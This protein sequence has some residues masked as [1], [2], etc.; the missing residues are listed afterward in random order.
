MK[1]Y[2]MKLMRFGVIFLVA[3]GLAVPAGFRGATA[4]K[5]ASYFPGGVC[6]AGT[7]DLWAKAGSITMPDGAAVPVWGFAPDAGSPAGLPGPT[8]VGEVGGTLDVVLHNNLAG[9]TVSLDF[10][11][12]PLVPD[13]TGV[14]TGGSTTYTLSLTKPG[15]FL[16]QAGLTGNGPRQVAMGLY[17]AI[18][19]RPAGQPLQAYDDV[20]TTFTDEALLVFSEIDP[21]FNANPNT[22]LMEDFNPRYWLINGKSF[23]QTEQYTV[24]AGRTVLFRYLNAGFDHH[25]IGLLGLRE[26]LVAKDSVPLSLPYM[27][28]TEIIGAGQTVDVL[29]QVPADAM[30]GKK[31][32]LYETS[33]IQHNANQRLAA[34]GPVAVGGMM[35]TITV[36]VGAAAPVTGALVINAQVNP[37]PTTGA[38]GVTL[39]ATFSTVVYGTEYFIDTI[40]DPGTGLGLGP[41]KLFVPVI[42]GGGSAPATPPAPSFSTSMFIPESIL[43]TLAGGY[44]NIYIRGKDANGVWGPVGSVVLNLDKVGPSAVG[45]GLTST[46]TNGQLDVEVRA[47]ADDLHYGGAVITGATYKIDNGATQLMLLDKPDVP[48]TA[49]TATIPAAV[50]M[51][52]SEGTHTVFVQATDSMGNMGPASSI[53]LVVDKSGPVTAP[54]TTDPP[55]FQVLQ[56]P[57]VTRVQVRATVTD[58]SIQP[59]TL[60]TAEGFIDGVGSSGT[61][62]A[63]FALDGVFD[64]VEEAV[65]FDIPTLNFPWWGVYTVTIHGKDAAGNWGPYSILNVLPEGP[66]NQVRLPEINR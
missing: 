17:G 4:V 61:G 22:Y 13:L 26:K 62:F 20:S 6:Q 11:G 35:T 19:V 25:S 40:G 56:T 1:K 43:A 28:T 52:L 33:L 41:I 39:T 55:D 10:L 5:A 7:C 50:V 42:T 63:V 65:Y 18:V 16:Y 27:V 3:L 44:H 2:T 59:S 12:F 54:I 15:T 21:L 32:L 46:P 36:A 47:T 8:L 29:V 34:A 58:L 51:G 57:Q 53:A 24:D 30:T 37:S 38:G 49:I 64:E 60:V 48:V 14:P 45:L 66:I 23:P 9:E 31:Y